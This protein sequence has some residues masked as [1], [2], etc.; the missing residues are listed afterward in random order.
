MFNFVS[1][2]KNKYYLYNLIF[3][4][5]SQNCDNNAEAFHISCKSVQSKKMH[6]LKNG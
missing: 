2:E 3:F 6:I 4:T 1:M 5:I